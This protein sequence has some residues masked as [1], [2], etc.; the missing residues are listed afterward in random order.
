MPAA[1]VA[2]AAWVWCC[3]AAWVW[4]CLA[5]AGAPWV[6]GAQH[7]SGPQKPGA[8]APQQNPGGRGTPHKTRQHLHRCWCKQSAAAGMQVSRQERLFRVHEGKHSASSQQAHPIDSLMAGR[9]CSA[10]HTAARPNTHHAELFGWQPSLARTR[11]ASATTPVCV[12]GIIT[13][14]D[15]RGA[16]PGGRPVLLIC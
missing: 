6:C 2:A 4:C 15:R 11:Q 16:H 10:T 7:P 14:P 12:E 9:P 5:A 1:A 13:Q 8:C 3:L